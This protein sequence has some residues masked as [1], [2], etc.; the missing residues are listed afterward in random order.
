MWDRNRLLEEVLG[1][2]GI[3]CLVGAAY[4]AFGR[5]GAL[6]VV[7]LVLLAGSHHYYTERTELT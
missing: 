4:L 6:V 3:G 2:A 5:A 1:W 7:G